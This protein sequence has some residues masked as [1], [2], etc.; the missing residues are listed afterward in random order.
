VLYSVTALLDE[1][2]LLARG[3]EEGGPVDRL[4]EA[5]QLVHSSQV[6]MLGTVDRANSE[7]ESLREVIR[8][9]GHRRIEEDTERMAVLGAARSI[10]DNLDLSRL[11]PLFAAMQRYFDVL[12]LSG[13]GRVAEAVESAIA[14]AVREPDSFLARGEMAIATDIGL[15][16]VQRGARLVAMEYS[17]FGIKAGP[18]ART[19]RKA[20][21]PAR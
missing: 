13:S 5:F 21:A 17:A 14:H 11:H 20:P 18:R 7:G 10:L 15:R 19:V 8:L 16:A 4:Y 12:P 1:A 3:R 6:D 9:F 2:A